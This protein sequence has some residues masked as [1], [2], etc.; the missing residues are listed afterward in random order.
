[1]KNFVFW[2]VALCGLS[3]IDVSEK[4]LRK[5]QI[6]QILSTLYLWDISSKILT[7]AIFAIA[8]QG[9]LFPTPFEHFHIPSQH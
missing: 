7:K 1:M 2:D 9:T 6:L 5:S 4:P 3:K 8:R